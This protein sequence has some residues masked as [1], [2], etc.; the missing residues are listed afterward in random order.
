MSESRAGVAGRGQGLERLVRDE[1]VV[2]GRGGWLFLAQ[3]SNFV[4][5]QHSGAIRLDDAALAQWR[6]TLEARLEFLRGLGVRYRLLVV[7][8]THGIY[9]EK[10][11]R[12]FRPAGERPV[13]QLIRHLAEHRSQVQVVYPLEEMIAAKKSGRVCSPVDSH[14]TAYG[15]F[16]AYDRLMD[17]IQPEVDFRR[18]SEEAIVFADIE[19]HADLGFKVGRS[20]PTTVAMMSTRARLVSDNCVENIGTHVVTECPSAPPTKCLLVGDSYA[21]AI[22]RYLAESFGR[23]VFVHS[24]TLDRDLIEAERPDVVISEMAERFL[25]AVPDDDNAPTVAER[26][27]RKLEA[28]RIRPQLPFWELPEPPPL[29]PPAPV[30]VER[31]RAAF[32]AKR[33]LQEA[34]F[35]SAMAYGGLRPRELL[36]LEWDA[37]AVDRIEIPAMTITAPTPESKAALGHGGSRSVRLLEP[38]AEDLERWRDA[39]GAPATGP[40][41]RNAEGSAL[42]AAEWHDWIVSEYPRTVELAGVSPDGARPLALRNTFATLLMQEGVP[43][44]QVAAETGHPPDA[45]PAELRLGEALQEL[46][47]VPAE[48]QVRLARRAV[49]RLRSRAVIKLR[50]WLQRFRASES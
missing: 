22:I 29:E 19:T 9:P 47:T 21:T 23:F 42:T 35:V 28:G 5:E 41:F 10:L 49:S 14:W 17:D 31:V 7:P 45:P 15:A 30:D 25:I 12:R 44:A 46:D 37:I 16:V 20:G 43:W 6:R 39:C 48:L 1:K 4:M 2:R 34:T 32:L 27:R 26:A 40:V 8:D 36:R 50:A 33:R 3:D 38:L 18:M 11:P 24:P 13:H